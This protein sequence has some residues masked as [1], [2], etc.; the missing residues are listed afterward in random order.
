MD[1]GS[2]NMANMMSNIRGAAGWNRGGNIF[3]TALASHGNNCDKLAV[4]VTAS[5]S[6]GPISRATR[7]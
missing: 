4:A 3:S 6:E 2:F 7:A 5:R 1:V